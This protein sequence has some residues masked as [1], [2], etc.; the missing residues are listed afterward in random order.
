[1]YV[2]IERRIFLLRAVEPYRHMRAPSVPAGRGTRRPN[3]GVVLCLFLRLHVWFR[4]FSVLITACIDSIN[5]WTEGRV[6]QNDR[7]QR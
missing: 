4:G 6:S 1:V 7:G 5:T 3:L 2:P